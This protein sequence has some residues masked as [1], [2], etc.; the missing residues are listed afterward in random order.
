MNPLR[1]WCNLVEKELTIAR[2]VVEG[3]DIDPSMYGGFIAPD[4][5]VFQSPDEAAHEKIMA[6][7]GLHGYHDAKRRGWVRFV[8]RQKSQSLFLEGQRDALLKSM[9]TWV[10]AAREMNW[11]TID[12]VGPTGA[13][14]AYEIYDMPQARGRML[15]DV[16]H[17]VRKAA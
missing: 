17:G 16:R 9:R 14:E 13:A 1:V 2:G 10:P 6:Q 12:Y 11:V 4:G 5:K 15:H 8:I 3:D 7:A